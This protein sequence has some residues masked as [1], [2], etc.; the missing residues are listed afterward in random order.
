MLL[1]FICLLFFRFRK[2]TSFIYTNGLFGVPVTEKRDYFGEL[3]L[4]PFEYKNPRRPRGL[5]GFVLD[6]VGGLTS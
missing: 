6:G 2:F 5:R 4:F 3:G 1:L